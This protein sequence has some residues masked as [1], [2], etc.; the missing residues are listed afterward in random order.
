VTQ[1]TVTGAVHAPATPHASPD[2]LNA[3]LTRVRLHAS[4][5]SVVLACAWWLLV[6][7][8]WTGGRGAGATT[9]GAVLTALA[10]L[11]TR[12]DQ[13]VPRRVLA[14]AVSTSVGALLV[15][16]LAPTGWAGASNAADYV[17]VSW[18]VVAV[19]AA[20]IRER[21]VVDLLLT[22]VVLGAALEFGESWLAWWGGGTA[23]RPIVG[24][25]Y[26]WDPFAAFLIPGSVLGLAYF[27]RGRGPVASLGL[28]GFATGSIGLVYSTSRAADACWVLAL[29]IVLAALVWQG[30]RTAALRAGAGLLVAGFAVWGV[31]GPPFFSHRALPFQSTAARASGQSLAQNGGYRMDFWHDALGVFSRHP[32][33]GGGFHSLATESVGHVARGSALSPLAHNGYLQALSD[34]GLVLAVPF[35]IGC[36]LVAWLVVS[37]LVRAIRVRDFSP[38]EFVLPLVLGALLAHSAVDFDWTFPADFALVAVLAGLLTGIRWADRPRTTGRSVPI[39]AGLALSGMALLGVAAAVSTAGDIHENLPIAKN[40]AG[41]VR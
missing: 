30:G 35:L 22:L 36:A 5:G 29:L 6:A 9:G 34:G 40:V 3:A 25:F 10:L 28:L 37:G 11:A 26:W 4:T 2:R 12:A 39:V 18:T 24:T 14:L 15:A 31:G 17:C 23:A 13:V 41:S 27:I 33:V 7:T 1:A 38:A 20:V 8:R 16:A 32:L 19:A 21:R